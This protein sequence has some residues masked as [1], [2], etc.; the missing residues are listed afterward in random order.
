MQDKASM[1]ICRQL[2]R[3]K[4]Y[5]AVI[6]LMLMYILYQAFPCGSAPSIMM[7]P[8]E[9]TKYIYDINQRAIPYD[10]N[11]PIIF[12][13]G[14]PRSGTTLMRAMLD[15]H[16]E[17][18]CGEETRVIPRILGMRTQWDKSAIEKKRLE[19]AGVTAEVLDS[20]V[21]AFIL[22]I[23]AK[24][25]SAA[26]HLCNK[27]PF[28]LK[29]TVYLSKQFPQSKYILMIRD[30]RAVV[31]SIISRKVT[32]S[33]FDLKSYRKCLIKWNAALETMYAQCMHVGPHKCMPV[34]YEQLALH[35]KEWME[36]ILNFLNIPWNESVLHH[37]DY[38]GKPGGIA[39]S[40]TEKSTDQ[41][42]KPVNIEALSKWVG[43]LPDDVVQ[44]MENIAPMLKTLGYDPKANPPNY[45]QPDPAV[46]DN[47]IHIKQ[48]ADFWRKREMDVLSQGADDQFPQQQQ[49]VGAQQEAAGSDPEKTA[50]KEEVS[51]R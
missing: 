50:P 31:H 5:F 15:A 39:L 30:G 22:E 36:R 35:P 42:I 25:G 49:G 40:K 48:N 21:R 38:V 8:K 34:Y 24:H 12:V 28:T 19:E 18:R 9:K 13:G 26:T 3:H 20:A 4:V 47:T 2:C 6:G 43:A 44:D 7:V 51:E 33:G 41:V 29:S 23:I 14:M 17:I 37:E 45:G 10:E 16:P 46:A 32:I 11:T 1:A 27:D